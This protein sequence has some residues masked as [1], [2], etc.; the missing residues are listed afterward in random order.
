MK[1]GVP[2]LLQN[3]FYQSYAIFDEILGHF[4][5]EDRIRF[6]KLGTELHMLIGPFP[7]KNAEKIL[8]LMEKGIL[9]VQALGTEY[10]IDEE[11][12]KIVVQWGQE[13]GMIA[14]HNFMVDATGQSGDCSTD[15]SA[16]ARSLTKHKLIREILVPF[17]GSVSRKV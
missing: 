5:A 7:V 16:L 4:S 14:R 10:S 15:Q 11:D 3:V 8:A 17:R 2:L 13:D 9:K 12:D 6:S 1:T